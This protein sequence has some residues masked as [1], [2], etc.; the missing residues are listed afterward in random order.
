LVSRQFEHA[1]NQ[2]SDH[3]L[4]ADESTAMQ[5]SSASRRAPR[6]GRDPFVTSASPSPGLGP[7]PFNPFLCYPMC[8]YTYRITQ[9]PVGWCRRGAT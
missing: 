5:S 7:R 8:I 6:T 3:V 1:A 4:V 9:E 2:R